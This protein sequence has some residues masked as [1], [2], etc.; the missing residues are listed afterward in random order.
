MAS[1]SVPGREVYRP[2]V[3]EV[4]RARTGQVIWRTRRK[5]VA[6]FVAWLFVGAD[7]APEGWGHV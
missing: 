3:W 5:W 6:Q 4:F 1:A 2:V 7:Y